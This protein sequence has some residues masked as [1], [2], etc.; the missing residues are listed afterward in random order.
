MINA[1]NVET[2]KAN[3]YF[4]FLK[5]QHDRWCMKY[6]L[7]VFEGEMSRENATIIGLRRNQSIVSEILIR[8]G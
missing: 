8:Q 3:T 4:S 6:T 1:Y 5:R 7:L 2:S